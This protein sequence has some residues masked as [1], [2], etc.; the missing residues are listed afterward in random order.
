[1]HARDDALLH[2]RRLKWRR[3]ELMKKPPDAGADTRPFTRPCSWGSSLPDAQ[4][5]AVAI[6]SSHH[7]IPMLE[8]LV[9]FGTDTAQEAVAIHEAI[10]PT[11]V[12]WT[13]PTNRNPLATLRWLVA[14]G[15]PVKPET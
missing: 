9:T 4:V 1:M 8:L 3:L 14:H 7:S 10:C 5:S 13:K 6:A 15:V 11:F 12:S 2:E